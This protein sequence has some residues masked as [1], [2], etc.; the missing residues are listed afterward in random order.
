MD[1]LPIVNDDNYDDYLAASA[2]VVMFGIVPCDNCAA[3]EPVVQRAAQ[4]L[5]GQVRFGK[6]KLHVPGATR[7]IKRRYRFESFPTTHFYKA[8]R[9]VHQVDHP[10]DYE[11]LIAEIQSRLIT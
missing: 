10:L 11:Q 8:G 1:P 6:A 7:E 4:A 2:A 3:F 5:G 9:L